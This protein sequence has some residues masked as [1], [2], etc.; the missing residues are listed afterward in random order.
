MADDPRPVAKKRGRPSATPPRTL[1]D[2]RI[3]R[4]M[5]LA[6]LSEKTGIGIPALSQI[7]RGTRVADPDQI[8]QLETAVGLDLHLAV[9]VVHWEPT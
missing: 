9:M 6:R 1:R 3:D 4:G 8:V 7:E 2:L 5:T